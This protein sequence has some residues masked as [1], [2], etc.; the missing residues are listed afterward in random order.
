MIIFEWKRIGVVMRK[1]SHLSLTGY[2][3]KS[4]D[5]EEIKEYKRSFYF[6][7][8]LPDCM[9][10][11]LSRRHTIESTFDILTKELLKIT[12]DYEVQ[13]GITKQYTRNLG[14]VTHY[15]ADYFTYPHNKIFEGTI[16]EHCSYE[17]TLKHKLKA[18]LKSQDLGK[19][20]ENMRLFPNAEVILNYIKEVHK[21]YLAVIKT[22]EVDCF[23]IVDLCQQVVNAILQ[24]Y[25]RKLELNTLSQIEIA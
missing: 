17:N 2:L 4:I 12:D 22:V 13:Q 6:G 15:I 10:S 20:T 5:V 24:I 14:V 18:Y 25:E 1:K 9:P 21:E 19:R 3:L 16:S 7:S 8:I 23:Y 11:F